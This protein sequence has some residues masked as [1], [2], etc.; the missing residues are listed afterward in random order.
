[1]LIF[2]FTSYTIVLRIFIAG[3]RFGRRASTLG[4][5]ADRELDN[6]I[7]RSSRS[8]ALPCRNDDRRTPLARRCSPTTQLARRCSP[9]SPLARRFSSTSPLARR[10]SP[11]SHRPRPSSASGT[12]FRRSLADFSPVSGTKLRQFV[13]SLIKLMCYQASPCCSDQGADLE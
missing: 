6:D 11:T 5:W 7:T 4:D 13:S 12:G 9:T 3:T 10:C 8:D 2:L 1:M